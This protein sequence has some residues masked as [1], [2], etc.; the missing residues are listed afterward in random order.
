VEHLT[1]ERGLSANTVAAYRADVLR[2]LSWARRGRR[3]PDDR[4]AVRA[5]LADLRR[6]GRKATTMGRHL[7]SLRGWYRF[8]VAEGELT[9]DPTEA[10]EAPR[11]GR[12]LPDVLRLEEVERVIAAVDPGRPLARRDRAILEMLYST[13]VRISEL[14]A[15][16]LSACDWE[17]RVVRVVPA[18]RRVRRRA[19][20]R[21][22]KAR[23]GP[24]GDKTRLVPVGRRAAEAARAWIDEERIFLK[25]SESEGALFLNARG[26]PLT[27][28]G[29]WKIVRG[30][31]QKAKI[32]RRVTPHTFRHTFATHLLDRG[33]DLRAVQEMLGHA[34]IATTQNYTH[35]D[36]PYLRA[37]HRR[38]HPRA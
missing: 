18:W 8:R 19:T 13:G 22:E 38:Y 30:Y 28:M 37:E 23:V 31:V 10:I 25:G 7:A 20:G 12:R 1:L 16:Q 27:R 24:K 29:A 11:P 33:A 26:R 21:T 3:D 9:A 15:L 36:P 14:V 4:A 32:G 6:R 2:Y 5:W 34:D 35:V 17:E